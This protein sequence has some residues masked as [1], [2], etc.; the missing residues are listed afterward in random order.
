MDGFT[1]NG[2]PFCLVQAQAGGQTE[3]GYNSERS[4]A[5]FSYPSRCL[6]TL[7]IFAQTVLT[8]LLSFS[9]CFSSAADPN[10]NF[11]NY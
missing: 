8:L 2:L 3:G 5:Y 1:E 9:L 11:Y 4:V 6:L 7:K 10:T